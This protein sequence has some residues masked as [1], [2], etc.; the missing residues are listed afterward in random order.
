[1]GFIV[2]LD[3]L[4]KLCYGPVAAAFVG[5]GNSAA[6]MASIFQGGHGTSS[7]VIQIIPPIAIHDELPQ[8]INQGR[9]P[10]SQ[11]ADRSRHP[12]Q[13]GIHQDRRALLSR[14]ARG[15]AGRMARFPQNRQ[16]ICLG[17]VRSSQAAPQRP[18][19]YRS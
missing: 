19:R 18:Q 4:K 3:Q 1:M 12:E 2:Q 17:Q 7:F 5:T 15:P 9:Q 14:A 10:F 16:A 6:R 11:G 13:G 8:L